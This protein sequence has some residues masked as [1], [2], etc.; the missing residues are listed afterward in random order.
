M[1]E[2]GAGCGGAQE[3]GGE[4]RTQHSSPLF[5]AVPGGARCGTVPSRACSMPTFC[6]VC[7][8]LGSWGPL[9]LPETPPHH[10]ETLPEGCVESVLTRFAFHHGWLS[11]GEESGQLLLNLP[12]TWSASHILF[13]RQLA[14]T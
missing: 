2:E 4:S 9:S 7:E 11:P 6:P 12:K 13:T 5:P 8:G 10:T 14:G 3:E 1:G